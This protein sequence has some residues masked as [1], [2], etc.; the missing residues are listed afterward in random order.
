MQPGGWARAKSE[1]MGFAPRPGAPLKFV[2]MRRLSEI[3][4][5]R[6]Q[7]PARVQAVKNGQIVL[8]QGEVKDGKILEVPGG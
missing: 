2:R 8:V 3:V 5:I 6:T 7:T 4:R 1:Q